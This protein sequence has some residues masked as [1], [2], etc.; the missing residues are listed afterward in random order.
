MQMNGFELGFLH[1]VVLS[2]G[3]FSTATVVFMV[4]NIVRGAK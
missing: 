3:I 1:A 2:L 4:I